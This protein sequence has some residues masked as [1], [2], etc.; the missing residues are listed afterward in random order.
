[1]CTG[2]HSEDSK[3]NVPSPRRIQESNLGCWI[4]RP[5]RKPTCD[6]LPLVSATNLVAVLLSVGVVLL[7]CLEGHLANKADV[8]L[9]D[10]AV[11]ELVL[12]QRGPRGEG[13]V[14]DVALEAGGVGMDLHVL[15]ALRLVPERLAAQGASHLA[16]ALRLC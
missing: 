5:T 14:A 7:L 3:K 8:P 2:V 6:Q 1:M 9:L 13:L 15:V 16:A 11:L 10:L 12:S 4:Y